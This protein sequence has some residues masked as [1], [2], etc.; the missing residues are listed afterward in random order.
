MHFFLDNLL[1]TFRVLTFQGVPS[2]AMKRHAGPGESEEFYD[3]EYA[4]QREGWV[5]RTVR[6]ALT[7]RA[8]RVKI[9]PARISSGIDTQ[10]QK[11]LN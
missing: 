2:D 9:L 7:R 4:E 10:R 5:F 8:T 11:Q 3:L 6:Q 1:D